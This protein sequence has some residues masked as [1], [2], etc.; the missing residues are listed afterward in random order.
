M[1]PEM[2]AYIM[3]F[4]LSFALTFSGLL[5]RDAWQDVPR[6]IAPRREPQCIE[7]LHGADRRVEPFP[8]AKHGRDEIA[9]LKTG[10]LGC[11]NF[12]DRASL[13]HFARL[14]R[15]APA[16]H[17][18]IGRGNLSDFARWRCPAQWGV[19]VITRAV[20]HATAHIRVDRHPEILHLHFAKCGGGHG[21]RCEFEIVRNGRADNTAFQTDFTRCGHGRELLLFVVSS[22]PMVLHLEERGFRRK[23]AA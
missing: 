2:V 10:V 13:Q 19:R 6:P 9:W 7:F 23:N 5:V 3:V 17:S 21:Y 8:P 18:R 22:S 12:T 16:V 11:N 1:T 4:C 15:R 20:D 14:E